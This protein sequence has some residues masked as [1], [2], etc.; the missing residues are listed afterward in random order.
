M[1]DIKVHVSLFTGE[2]FWGYVYLKDDERVQDLMNDDRKFIP[3]KKVHLERGPKSQVTESNLV[4]NKDAI[5]SLEE[6]GE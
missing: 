6:R 2:T 1:K 3:F 5:A 4:V